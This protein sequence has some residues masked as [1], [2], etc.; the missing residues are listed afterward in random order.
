MHR[1]DI[2]TSM[3]PSPGSPPVRWRISDQPV[4]YEDAVA[5]M[6]REATLIA[7]GQADEL[8]W[9]VEHPPLYTAGTS[10]DP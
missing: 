6:E 5:E 9:L 1:S 4:G 2:T 10:A 3:L 7:D 8:V